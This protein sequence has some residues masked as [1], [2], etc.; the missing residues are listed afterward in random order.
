M[1]HMFAWFE[2]ETPSGLAQ[3]LQGF[4][5]SQSEQMIW[6]VDVGCIYATLAK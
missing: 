1:L 6:Q 5:C 4:L 2:A 3:W